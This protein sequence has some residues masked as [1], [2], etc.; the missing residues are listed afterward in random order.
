MT[1]AKN[2][3]AGRPKSELKRKQILESA[4]E[5]FL[6]HGYERTSMDS[7][8]KESG[9]SKQ[10]VY[11]HFKNKDAL[12]NAVIESKCKSYQLEETSI[13]QNDLPLVDILKSFAVKFMQLLSDEHVISMY[14]AVIGEAQNTPRVAQLFYDAGPVHSIEL[15]QQLLQNHSASKLSAENAREASIDFFNLLKGEFHMRS[16]LHLP[17]KL[18]KN[19]IEHKALR[20]AQKIVLIIEHDLQ[21]K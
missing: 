5:M 2:P 3:T 11:S 13:C 7:V 21:K 9:V 16:L 20:T 19:T 15:I 12:Y 1:E 6:Q 17:Y 18:D 14:N 4:A 8:A 10:T